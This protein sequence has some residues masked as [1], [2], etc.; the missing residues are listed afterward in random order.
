MA[1]NRVDTKFSNSNVVALTQQNALKKQM[2]AIAQNI[3]NMN[4]TAARSQ[5]IVFSAQLLESSGGRGVS[6]VAEKGLVRD[7]SQGPIE[8]TGNDFDIALKGPGY[9]SIQTPQGIRYTRNG[10]LHLDA[11]RQLV[12]AQGHPVLS[13]AQAPIVVPAGN[14]SI[15]IDPSGNIIGS[16]GALGAFAIST[17]E[18]EQ[19]LIAKGAGLYETSQVPSPAFNARVEQGS[20]EGSNVNAVIEATKLIEVSR[21]YEQNQ[22]FMQKTDQKIKDVIEKV[23]RV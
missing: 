13:K 7:L 12:T 18:N 4:T 9:L 11:Q 19:A 8:H 2:E 20:L 15:H 5:S 3:A 14:T 23:G 22:A 10:N 21:M 6:F 1:V 17:F 16:G